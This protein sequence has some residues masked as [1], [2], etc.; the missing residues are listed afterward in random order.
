MNKKNLSLK[1]ITGEIKDF[2]KK[3]EWDKAKPSNIAKSIIIEAAELLELF[4]W[5]H[6]TIEETKQNKEL[7]KKIKEELADV[8]IYSFDMARVLDIDLL[9]IM[10]K[11]L[12]YNNKK[13]PVKLMKQRLKLS[14]NKK[15]TSQDPYIAIKQ[16]HR[17]TN[18]K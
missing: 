9:A 18:K 11:K 16:N 7:L 5:S 10:H 2:L 12:V 3:R 15:L 4:Q 13:F 8:L 6:L 14:A 1:K 17:R